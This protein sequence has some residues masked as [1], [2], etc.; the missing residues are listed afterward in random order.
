MR[1]FS[2]I[3]VKNNSVRSNTTI[4]L[5]LLALGAL[6]NTPIEWSLKAVTVLTIAIIL[7]RRYILRHEHFVLV[8]VA[9]TTALLLVSIMLP[10]LYATL[11]IVGL[12]L[13][14][15]GQYQ[16]S[17]VRPKMFSKQNISPYL[18][19]SLALA[20]IGLFGLELDF[21]YIHMEQL[22]VQ[23]Q[24][25]LGLFFLL[26]VFSDMI[27]KRAEVY[28]GLAKELAEKER[29]W[30]L[31][32]LSLLSHNIRTPMATMT[33]RIEVIKL[34]LNQNLP[35]TKDDLESLNTSS[36]NVNNIVNQLL[37]KTARNQIKHKKGRT[38]L[39]NCIKDLDNDAFHVMNPDGIDFDLSSTNAIALQLCLDSLLS[40][41]VKYGGTQNHLVLSQDTYHY[42]ITVVD[43]GIGMTKEQIA[44]YGTPFN[45]SNTKGGTGLGV[46]FTLKLLLDKGWD[47]SISSEK[48]KGTE[49]KI[50]IPKRNLF[51]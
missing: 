28:E 17:Y 12:I 19:L 45:L 42:H 18:G 50:I 31:E 11:I 40:N 41:A 22:N 14:F 36:V 4:I 5:T 46:Y 20:K 9:E 1:H 47:W 44:T 26:C 7:I 49:V 34:K 27:K 39:Y 21:S 24:S 23:T 32:L 43:D 33:S 8:L 37:S 35:I 15:R 38:N 16:P 10:G 2:A 13:R 48:F 25:A 51:L 29:N 3:M 30:T 6:V